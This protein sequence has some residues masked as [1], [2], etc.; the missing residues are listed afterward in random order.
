MAKPAALKK[1]R[2][3]LETLFCEVDANKD[4]VLGSGELVKAV[5]LCHANF[6]PHDAKTLVK[7]CYNVDLK[8]EH[9]ISALPPS[10]SSTA[11]TPMAQTR[12]TVDANPALQEVVGLDIVKFAKCVFAHREL[13]FPNDAKVEKSSASTTT[14]TSASSSRRVTSKP[15]VNAS[16]RVTLPKT[17]AGR[18]CG[19]AASKRTTVSST[20]TSEVTK[21]EKPINLSLIFGVS[22]T[23]GTRGWDDVKKIEKLTADVEAAAKE[24]S[25]GKAAEAP[26][27]RDMMYRG[28]QLT[29]KDTQKVLANTTQIVSR[30]QGNLESTKR[31]SEELDGQWDQFQKRFQQVNLAMVARLGKAM[32]VKVDVADEMQELQRGIEESKQLT[33]EIAESRT[34]GKKPEKDFTSI[35]PTSASKKTSPPTAPCTGAL[36]A[37]LDAVGK[38]AGLGG[39]KDDKK[40]P[41]EICKLNENLKK[42]DSKSVTAIGNHLKFVDALKAAQKTQGSGRKRSARGISTD[43]SCPPVSSARGSKPSLGLGRSSLANKSL[44]QT[45]NRLEEK[46]EKVSDDA[47]TSASSSRGANGLRDEKNASRFRLFGSGESNRNLEEMLNHPKVGAADLITEKMKIAGA[48]RIERDFPALPKVKS[49]DWLAEHSEVGQSCDGFMRRCDSMFAKPGCARNVLYIQPLGTVT[50]KSMPPGVKNV[51]LLADKESA[52]LKLLKSYLVAFFGRTMEVK[53]LPFVQTD[54]AA[55]RN[56]DWDG[57]HQVNAGDIINKVLP[58]IRLK[59][60]DAYAFIGV[61][62]EDLYPRDSWNFVFGLA[63]MMGRNGVFSFAR[64]DEDDEDYAFGAMLNKKQAPN[65]DLPLQQRDPLRYTRLL[66]RACKV[67]THELCHCFGAKHCVHFNCLMQGSNSS[68]EAEKKLHDLCPVCLKKI[69]YACEFD[70]IERY[71]LMKNWVDERISEDGQ[72]AEHVF[73]EW[74]DW[75]GRRIEACCD[76]IIK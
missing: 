13:T 48:A 16:S 60:R 58:D 76:A 62:M 74:S 11:T 39:L 57:R 54:K 37:S 64:Y 55:Y 24:L 41:D 36:K 34:S 72:V 8:T 49:G 19:V 22:P 1:L 12:W 27:D 18:S 23:V 63:D 51:E 38:K 70:P 46:S 33:R 75:F 42:H 67:M 14:T 50:G 2:T 68:E 47:S 9:T 35:T 31:M 10:S 52:F 45:Y 40:R 5:G 30:T 61:T 17:G 44:V 66:K 29:L 65:D 26:R 15:S 25:S 3:A 21:E 73:G 71:G 7:S 69:M 6:L 20:K 59:Y 4:G 43:F 56:N 28:L 53:I 32:G